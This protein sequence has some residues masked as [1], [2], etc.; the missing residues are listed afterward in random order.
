M[1]PINTP[2]A[3]PSVK[4]SLETLPSLRTP[5]LKIFVQS[6][7]DCVLALK[8][9][10]SDH[11]SWLTDHHRYKEAWELVQE[12]PEAVTSANDD[13]SLDDTQST[14][15]KQSKNSLRDFFADD[16]ASQT[17]ISQSKVRKGVIENEQRRIGELWLQQ[18]VSEKDWTTAGQVAGRVLGASPRWEHWIWTFAQAGRFDE[19]TPYVPTKQLHPPLP[20]IVYERLLGHYL[21]RDRPRFKELIDGWDVDLFHI[22]SVTS[23]IE[24][25][26]DSDEVTEIS[27]E[28]GVEGRDWKILLETLAK[29]K[30]ADGRPKET[31]RC[32]IK[33][34]NSDAAMALIGQYHLVEA[35]AD[36]IPGFLTLRVSKEHL[37]SASLSE[38]EDA[39][40]D[41]IRL[42]VDESLT[43][44]VK[45][46]VV[47]N[48]LKAKGTLYR[49]FLFLYLR[50]LWKGHTAEHRPHRI[51]QRL[52]SEGRLYVEQ[53]GDLAVTLFAEYDRNLLLEF[54]RASR[55]YSY[56]K[57]TA[58]CEQKNFYPELVYLFSQTGQ[59][60]RALSLII[61][62][63]GDVK[64]AIE[65]AKEQN[66]AELWD[67]LLDFSMDKPRFIR[68]LLEEVGTTINPI[69]L[70]RRIPEGLEIEGLRDGVG[71]ILREYEIQGSISEGVARV[72]RGEVASGMEILRQGRAKA[73][74]FDIHDDVAPTEIQAVNEKVAPEQTEE[75]SEG[76]NHAPKPGH[77]VQCRQAFELD[78]ESF[79]H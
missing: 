49:P 41:A 37:S 30:L 24:K 8:R 17:T 50:S 59:T 78:G 75:R 43:G 54:L 34:Q 74:K 62:S 58:V 9:D 19:I 69:K 22:E 48:Q 11:L 38:L 46:Q 42:L 45:P 2:K 51:H 71:R 21:I 60:K 13:L 47:I 18:L 14:P 10:L 52:E 6:P 25:K 53:D 7:Y 27:V 61:N 35:V 76:Q 73:V 44:V 33:L 70:V 77:C 4:K 26:L 1:K 56:E 15:T 57:A 28:D 29:L 23:A 40:N 39:S 67:D 3:P 66:D 79:I 72:L 20:S 12:Y 64:F 31:L 55:S 5:G 65:F 68:G 32:Y 63:L 16:A 36:D